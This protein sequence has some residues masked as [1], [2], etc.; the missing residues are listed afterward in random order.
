MTRHHYMMLGVNLAISLLIMYVAMFAMIWSWGEFIQ[1]VNFFYMALV[2][3]AP[4][5]AVMLLTM[6]PMYAS[7]RLNVLLY[8]LFAIV[9]LLSFAGIRAQALVGDKQFLSSMIPTIRAR[10]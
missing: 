1:N 3:W 6:K 5:A 9:F 2:M 10:S 7:P 8:A 4:M